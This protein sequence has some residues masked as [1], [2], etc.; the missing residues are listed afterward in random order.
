MYAFPAAA[1]NSSSGMT[2]TVSG[3]V[4]NTKGLPQVG[5][6]LTFRNPGC[7]TVTATTSSTGQYEVQLKPEALWNVHLEGVGIKKTYKEFIVPTN[8]MTVGGFSD[9]VT[10]SLSTIEVDLG[11]ENDSS[12][13]EDGHSNTETNSRNAIGTNANTSSSAATAAVASS[14]EAKLSQAVVDSLEKNMASYRE[15]ATLIANTILELMNNPAVPQVALSANMTSLKHYCNLY[16]QNAVCLKNPPLQLQRAIHEAHHRHHHRR[17]SVQGS[18]SAATSSV[19][20]LAS[21]TTSS[22]SSSFIA[23]ADANAAALDTDSKN[24]DPSGIF[25]I[26]ILTGAEV[27]ALEQELY[28]KLLEPSSDSPPPAAEASH[29]AKIKHYSKALSVHFECYAEKFSMNKLGIFANW[30]RRRFVLQGCVISYFTTNGGDRC[31]GMVINKNTV[32]NRECTTAT[33]P[34]CREIDLHREL[35]IDFVDTNSKRLLLRFDDDTTKNKWGDAIED[36]IEF[37]KLM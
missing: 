8:G 33:H 27:N 25:T 24:R 5:M 3:L 11:N 4:T 6:T 22:S 13:S 19:T 37:L 16:A 20:V 35:L 17:S 32:L 9:I 14:S 26:P 7:D 2:V 30:K 23:S 31:G 28:F 34:Q 29:A 15:S 21:T 18:D 10:D 12:D 1:S 36:L